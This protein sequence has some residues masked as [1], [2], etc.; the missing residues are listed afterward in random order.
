MMMRPARGA[1]PWLA[2]LALGL[3]ATGLRA[4]EPAVRSLDV[5][6][7]QVGG[8][9][10]LVID[11]DDFG[12]SPH[13][14][15]PFPARQQ[16][17]KGATA[18]RGTF[19]VT[20]GA[21]VVPG[22]YQL[23]VVSGSG[24]SPPVVIAVDRLPQRLLA[25]T[26]GLLPA[27]LHGTIGGST[28]AETKFA[29][30]A[31][32]K[33]LVEVEANRL[34]SKL[35]PVLHLY[36]PK[37]LQI[38]WSWPHPTLSGDTRLE[39]TLP[40]DGEFT[41]TVHDVEYAVPGPGFFRLRLGQWAYVDQVF[42]PVI[43]RGLPQA[44]ELLGSPGV[45]RLTAPPA[46]GQAILPLAWPGEG[47]WSGPRPLVRVSRH[48]EVIGQSSAAGPQALPAAPVGVSGRL[49]VPFA[50]DRYRLAVKPGTRLK[51]EA[52]AERLGS[53]L[54]TALVVRNEK[55]DQLARA[56]DGPGT[57][58]P[59]LEYTVPDKVM[60]LVVGVVDAQGRGGPRGIYRLIVEPQ[61]AAP[62]FRLWVPAQQFSLPAGGTA[63]IPVLAERRGNKGPITITAERLPAWAL[64]EGA[65]IPEGADGTL[66][67]LRRGPSP[68]EPAI[69]R[70]LGRGADGETHPVVLKGHPLE[71][72]QPWLAEEIALAPT[73]GK[74]GDF[75]VAWNNLPADVGLVPAR[76]LVLPVKV[77]RP[78]TTSAVRL[79]LL[80]SQLVPQVN[81]Q[82]DLNKALRL[83]K[84]TE[85]GPKTAEEKLTILVPPELPSPVYDVTIQGELLSPDKSTVL[86]VAYAPVRRLAVRWPL[87]VKLDGPP[88]IV[89][90]V[91]PKKGATIK[92]QGQ[93]ERREGLTGDVALTLTGLPA[94]ARP[95]AMTVKAAATAFALN[96]VLAANQPPGEIRGLKLFGTAAA[97]PKQPNVRV[98]SRDVEV[99]LFVQA[100]GK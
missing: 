20:L 37:R 64:L 13:L 3:G 15:L 79:K 54:D 96:V 43:A 53:P 89:A 8:T 2:L 76:K 59:G 68:A 22:Y 12:S 87:V 38:A 31:G 58:D 41:V 95:D 34:G 42:P 21:D 65:L 60:A 62:D 94:G 81:N 83:E 57:L 1:G 28:V 24:V 66:V 7:L 77:R 70:W 86:A 78:G 18:T 11:G 5:R 32:Q 55:G 23:R 30:K 85:L 17:K 91:D 40:E 10:A 14:L 4:A 73:V 74:A 16:L 61:P 47:S 82:P 36:S 93:V 56:E 80:T 90:T 67:T 98:R 26:A 35:R 9:T 46:S 88:R 48:A 75:Q 100:A 63:V 71:R 25:N 27:A 69:T 84:A 51:L 33:I 39:A 97:D 99:T 19:D 6:G 72:L 29:G 52:F 45:A 49:L 50:E 44:L 92:I